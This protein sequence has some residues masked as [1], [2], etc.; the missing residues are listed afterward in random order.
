M[1]DADFSSDF[2]FYAQNT[3]TPVCAFQTSGSR[4]Q[5]LSDEQ[6]E[7]MKAS[8]SRLRQQCDNL[9]L[10]SYAQKQKLL[11]KEQRLQSTLDKHMMTLT[12]ASLE[13]PSN[14]SSQEPAGPGEFTGFTEP[15]EKNHPNTD[16]G[17]YT[18]GRARSRRFAR[19]V[20]DNL[21]LIV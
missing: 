20:S 8:V 18:S 15:A 21:V 14:E 16:L 2:D 17:L 3:Q 10:M 12:T 4:T 9:S 5:T 1:N 11:Q 19:L 6:I 13:P 7:K